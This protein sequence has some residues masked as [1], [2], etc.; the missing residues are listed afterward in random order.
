M[1]EVI[2]GID[3]QSSDAEKNL[4]S[5]TAKIADNRKLLREQKKALDEVNKT[6]GV[7]SKQSIQAAK[8]VDQLTAETK[9][10]VAEQKQQVKQSEIVAGSLNDQR[11]Q[12]NKL[13]KQYDNIPRGTQAS[14]DLQ[15]QIVALTA[16]VKKGEQATERFS[17][18]V[19]SYKE[20]VKQALN[21]SGLF[22]KEL[23]TLQT[24]QKTA[25]AATGTLTKSTNLLSLAIKAIPIVAIVSAFIG[26]VKAFLSTQ[27]GADALNRVLVPIKALFQ[28]LIGVVQDLAVKGF[29]KLVKAINDPKAALEGLAKSIKEGIQERF[30]S[31]LDSITGVG[32]A[33][34]KLFKDRDL[35]GAIEEGKKA[36]GSY[37]DA[38]NPLKGITDAIADSTEGLNKKIQESFQTGK[39]IE[40]LTE[41]FQKLQVATTVPIARARLEFQKLREIAQ[42]QTKT[43]EERVK[44]LEG[45][46]NKLDEITK[47]E[48][49]LL[50][51]QIKI[52]EAEQSLNDTDRSE[53]LE[54]E[55][56]KAQQLN[57]QST[58]Q[59]KKNSLVSLESGIQIKITKEKEKQLKLDS[60]S[61][62]EKEKS[63]KDIQE[64]LQK[65]NELLQQGII[66][67]ANLKKQA[68]AEEAK[69][70][71]ELA[72]KIVKI[73]QE[74]ENELK[75]LRLEAVELEIEALRFKNDLTI[76]EQARLN[77]LSL[78]EEQLKT[79]L[80]LE[81]KQRLQ[82]EEEKI[83]KRRI[84][85]A[86][87]VLSNASDIGQS[88]Q[89]LAK[90][91][92]ALAKVGFLVEK[93]AAFASNIVNTIK[94]NG[95]ITGSESIPVP[96][97]PALIALNT[98]AGVARGAAIT[99]TTIQ[100]FK[101]GGVIGEK[102]AKGGEV[103]PSKQGGFIRGNSHANGGVKFKVG[104]VTNEAEGGEIILTKR[105]G[106]SARGRKIA[107]DLNASFGGKKFQSGDILGTSSIV[108]DLG[109]Q[110][111]I[112]RLI[113]ATQQTK[114]VQVVSDFTDV[115]DEQILVEDRATV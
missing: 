50:D 114:I 17:R 41:Q 31:F 18:G 97:K 27:R 103:F 44:A 21:E 107:S 100:G 113:E 102:Y 24:I 94:G 58:N 10:L 82:T 48:E 52:K 12:L 33:L 70:K 78:E 2:F 96:A 4:A 112:E 54:L 14:K 81:E 45:A 61:Q 57:V 28:G 6:Y 38:I 63:L 36:L 3:I 47:T 108:N 46:K 101:K 49:K 106:Q 66:N 79:D 68:A 7:G 59:K 91:G 25:S 26:L 32:R 98:A 85:I 34:V 9:G 29:D 84:A 5:L 35:S 111:S 109:E 23:R 93:A 92:S 67:E 90:E 1:E 83:E 43:N 22:S 99:A 42:D 37:V 86:R 53:A 20:N 30:N 11:N 88:L 73:E 77:A 16:K 64:G 19:G 69:T 40:Q 95:Q 39:R 13:I 55:N 87:Q 62:K 115:Q 71:Q 89:T 65:E 76:E 15:K 105:V 51:L 104:G 72:D 80:F 75:K 56:L 8:G 60:D 110:N 74:K